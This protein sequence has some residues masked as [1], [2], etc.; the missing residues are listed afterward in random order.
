[1]RGW[2]KNSDIRSQGSKK[3]RISHENTLG[4]LK[5]TGISRGKERE[6]SALERR[7][8]KEKKKGKNRMGVE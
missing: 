6:N 4:F 7:K 8:E 2:R 1:V 3:V 5:G